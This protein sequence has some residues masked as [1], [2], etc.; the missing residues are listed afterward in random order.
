MKKILRKLYT[1]AII[2]ILLAFY[3]S[4]TNE[5]QNTSVPANKMES[6]NEI[7]IPSILEDNNIDA[8]SLKIALD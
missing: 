1:L 5:S 6:S 8:P 3:Y 2:C 7:I 4:L